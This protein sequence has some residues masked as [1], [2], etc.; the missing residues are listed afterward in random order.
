MIP[1][2]R[3]ILLTTFAV[4][5]VGGHNETQRISVG[6]LREQLIQLVGDPYLQI[7]LLQVLEA[8]RYTVV[9]EISIQ[10]GNRI[11]VAARVE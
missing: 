10:P 2:I 11:F 5:H 1:T 6:A 3:E 8:P 9:R 4:T 7:E